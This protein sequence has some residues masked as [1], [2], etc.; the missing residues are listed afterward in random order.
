MPLP[1]SKE[2]VPN[3]MDE[4]EEEATTAATRDSIEDDDDPDK[5][6]G[7]MPVAL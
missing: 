4:D 7:D 6:T 5:D 2:G 3:N 1:K